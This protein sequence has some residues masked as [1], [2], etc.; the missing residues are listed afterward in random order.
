MPT[1]LISMISGLK[2]SALLLV[3]IT[4][5]LTGQ[6]TAMTPPPSSQW[7][8]AE[9][10]DGVAFQGDG[11]INLVQRFVRWSRGESRFGFH[12]QAGGQP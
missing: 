2:D 9:I 7:P 10:V 8:G 5:P 11:G 12:R 3:A 1:S 4:C 6:N